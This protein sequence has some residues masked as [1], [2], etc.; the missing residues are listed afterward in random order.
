MDLLDMKESASSIKESRDAFLL[1]KRTNIMNDSVQFRYAVNLL[2]IT[3][4]NSVAESIHLLKEVF[5]HTRDDDLKRDCLYY[6]AVAYTKISD[7][8]TATK[9][10]DSVLVM[11]PLDQQVI[12][13]KDEVRSRAFKAGVTGLVVGGIALGAAALFGIGLAFGRSRNKRH[14]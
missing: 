3:D 8:E 11:Q 9:Y 4:E 13:L 12:E 2:R 10:C 6:L 5:N 7:Y 14:K 1:M